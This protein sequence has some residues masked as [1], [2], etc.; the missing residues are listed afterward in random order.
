M[1]NGSLLDAVRAEISSRL[2][3]ALKG[4]DRVSADALRAA[5]SALDNASAQPLSVVAQPFPY[6][7]SAEVPRREL[8]GAEI[9]ALLV[10]EADAHAA[11]AVQYE[12]LGHA[13]RADRLRREAEIIRGT[14]EH[15]AAADTTPAP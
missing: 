14:L 3:S 11:A 7:S 6:G 4:R 5:L 8:S 9:E 1:S 10:T 12:R 13:D 15:V 2:K